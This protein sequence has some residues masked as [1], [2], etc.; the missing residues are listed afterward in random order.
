MSTRSHDDLLRWRVIERVEGEDH[1]VF[2]TVRHKAEH[3]ATGLTKDFSVLKMPDW[4]NV[5][6]LTHD[7]HVVMVRQFRHGTDEITLEIPG[8]AVD[9]GET[10]GDA[11]AR[12][13]REETGYEAGAWMRLGDVQPNPAIQNN[14]CS[15]WLATDARRVDSPSPDE[16]EVLSVDEVPLQDIPEMLRSGQIRHGIVV[17]AF[18]HLL[19]R[20]SGKWSRPPRNV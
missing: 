13:L 7:D 12:E 11:V 20:T 3:P 15:T 16:G 8:G 2:R 17:A 18:A 9:P 5:I 6:A 4:A 10:H 19:L 1:G 14:V